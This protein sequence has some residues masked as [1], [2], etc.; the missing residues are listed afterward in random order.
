MSS[1]S[2][3]SAA[4]FDG[5]ALATAGN[6]SK[7]G[8]RPK[9][10][11]YIGEAFRRRGFAWTLARYT[12]EAQTS[13]SSLGV[14]YHVLVPA[15]QIGV[16]G[17]I[18]GLILGNSRPEHF[19]PYLIVGI[20]LFQY[21]SGSITDGAKAITSNASLVRSLDFPR[22]LLPVSAMISNLLKVLPLVAL[23]LLAVWGFGEPV[24]WD[25]F[26]IIPVFALMT[27]FASGLAMIAA[28]LTVHL[29][30]LNQL[31]PFFIRVLFYSSG[32]FYNVDKLSM[33]NP[34]FGAIL[35]NNPVHI[36]L[37]LARASLVDTYTATATDWVVAAV[38]AVVMFAAGTW[39]FWM[40]EE[41]YG[42][43][44]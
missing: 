28:R 37:V 41:K 12:L 15:L 3:A 7:M 18:F 16:Y 39:F 11:A 42:R 8:T 29:E 1:A 14:A 33:G 24:G 17:I 26:L 5:L 6:L 35:H 21:I 27:V 30:D 34:V 10:L 38:W 2:S 20:V 40:A 25:W 32:I 36:F 23:M 44:V 9:F 19:V 4:S 22:V 13:R 43:N 31:L